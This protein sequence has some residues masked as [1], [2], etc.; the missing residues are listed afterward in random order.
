MIRMRSCT[1]SAL[2]I[3]GS[4]CAKTSSPTPSLKPMTISST[5]LARH[6]ASLPQIPKSSHQS[7]NEIGQMSN[8]PIVGF[9]RKLF[10]R[11]A[12][13]GDGFFQPGFSEKTYGHVIS[14]P[15]SHHC[16]LLAIPTQNKLRHPHLH[17]FN[18]IMS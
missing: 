11:P 16:C 10:D 8:D 1:S 3:S 15:S 6:G 13:W 2:V 5:K 9:I 12:F 14:Q 7:P 4:S 17:Q 18:K